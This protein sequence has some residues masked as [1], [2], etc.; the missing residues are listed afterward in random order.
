M[1]FVSVV[2]GIVSEVSIV[3]ARVYAV[4]EAITISSKMV[5]RGA[6][7]SSQTHTVP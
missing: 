4:M 3:T 1:G 2:G 7:I 6:G 5:C